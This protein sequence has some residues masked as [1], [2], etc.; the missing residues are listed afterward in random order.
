MFNG[1]WKHLAICWPLMTF[2]H[3]SQLVY[4][5]NKYKFPRLTHKISGSFAN[6]TPEN[7]IFQQ[8]GNESEWHAEEAEHQVTDSQ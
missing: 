1:R 2:S 3:I 8:V 4:L 5:Q 7:K 6:S